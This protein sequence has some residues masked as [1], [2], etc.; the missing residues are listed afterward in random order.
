MSITFEAQAFLNI[1]LGPD[2]ISN[3]GKLELNPLEVSVESIYEYIYLPENKTKKLW[4]Y[5]RRSRPKVMDS[6]EVWIQFNIKR[7]NTSHDYSGEKANDTF[8]I[9]PSFIAEAINL[10]ET[11]SKEK[12]Q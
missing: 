1:G 3:A 11:I 2:Q 5:L 7:G 12:W 10:Y 9:I 6:A 8:E 4:K